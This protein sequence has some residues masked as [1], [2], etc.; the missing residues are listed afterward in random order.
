MNVIYSELGKKI[1]AW[2]EWCGSEGNQNDHI[3]SF[4]ADELSKSDL[5]E[6]L[7]IVTRCVALERLPHNIIGDQTTPYG[8]D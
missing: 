7:A 8:M 3:R 5:F 6:I 1:D 2:K 4:F